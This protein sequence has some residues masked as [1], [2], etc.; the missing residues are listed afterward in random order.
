MRGNL[1][2][3]YRIPIVGRIGIVRWILFDSA[4]LFSFLNHVQG[5]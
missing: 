1:M 4:F 3:R 2:R 5:T